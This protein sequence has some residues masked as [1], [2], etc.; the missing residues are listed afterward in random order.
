MNKHKEEPL[1][2]LKVGSIFPSNIAKINYNQNTIK[3]TKYEQNSNIQDCFVKNNISFTGKEKITIKKDITEATVLTGI[4]GAEFLVGLGLAIGMAKSGDKAADILL[5]KDGYKINTEEK[6]LTSNFINADDDGV[7]QIKGTGIDI[8]PERFDYV[9]TE[10]GI[11]KNITKGIEIDLLNHKYIDPEN[12]IFIDPASK[13]SSI[14]DGN[15]IEH[16]AVPDLSF[17]SG[18]APVLPTGGIHTDGPKYPPSSITRSEFTEKYGMTPEAYQQK[19]GQI[20]EHLKPDD[21]RTGLQKI[22]DFFVNS[23]AVCDESKEYDIFGREII[24]SI[25]SDG[26][27][28]LS[29]LPNMQTNPI[30]KD[31]INEGMSIQE[32]AQET[33]D[34]EFKSYIENNYPNFGTRLMVYE[35][36][37]DSRI[38]PLEPPKYDGN[39]VT[40]VLHKISEDGA[41]TPKPG[42][43]EAVEFFKYQVEMMK[44]HTWE[45]PMINWNSLLDSNLD[46]IGDTL[47]DLDGDGIPDAIDLDGDG[48]PDKL[49]ELAED[50]DADGFIESIFE[51]IKKLFGRD[52]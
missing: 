37:P 32:A 30:F 29:T 44:S 39:L 5:D 21:N 22:K 28:Y 1:M 17:G 6:T 46:N 24:K 20:L 23:N 35:G 7:F 11:Y 50:S 27:T 51:A 38:I 16:I 18:Q 31:F 13:I 19:N 8:T 2:S 49:I 10:N 47:I 52:N 15:N 14:L 48:I 3:N 12:G 25:D 26:N 40:N 36:G 33:H 42:S 43:S 41:Y 4:V 45:K 9:D 34:L